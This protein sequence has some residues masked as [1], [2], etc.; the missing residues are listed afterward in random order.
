MEEPAAGL[1]EGDRLSPVELLM[2]PSRPSCDQRMRLED[3]LSMVNLLKR[4]SG[5]WESTRGPKRKAEITFSH[6]ES[7]FS[8]GLFKNTFSAI[9]RFATRT[10][11][12]IK[13]SF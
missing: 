6:F 2:N 4:P 8:S 10:V 12:V 9:Y 13:S 11:L 7:V 3:T 5:F 1:G